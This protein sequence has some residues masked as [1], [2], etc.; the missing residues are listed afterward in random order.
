VSDVNHS[1]NIV[2]HRQRTFANEISVILNVVEHW[3]APWM[4]LGGW[5]HIDQSAS[6]KLVP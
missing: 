6:I 3:L 2:S 1:V 4:I 5:L